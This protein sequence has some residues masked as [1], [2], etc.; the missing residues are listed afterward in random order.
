MTKVYVEGGCKVLKS[1][2]L[3]KTNNSFCELQSLKGLKSWNLPFRFFPN[4]LF[5]ISQ[6]RIS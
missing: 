4:A 5:Y 2:Y 6:R 1:G 3:K